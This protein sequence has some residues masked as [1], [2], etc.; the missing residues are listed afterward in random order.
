M[1]KL[2]QPPDQHTQAPPAPP[3]TPDI[4]SDNDS[5][6]HARR[7]ELGRQLGG[8]ANHSRLTEDVAARQPHDD[9]FFSPEIPEEVS[10]FVLQALSLQQKLEHRVSS[11]IEKNDRDKTPTVRRHRKDSDYGRRVA[12]DGHRFV[13]LL[14]NGAVQKDADQVVLTEAGFDLI[15]Y[16]IE[17]NGPPDAKTLVGLQNIVARQ[18]ISPVVPFKKGPDGQIEYYPEVGRANPRYITE[19]GVKI[20]P[21]DNPKQDKVAETVKKLDP[22]H[23][24]LS[25]DDRE[26]FKTLLSTDNLTKPPAPYAAKPHR[27]P[28]AEKLGLRKIAEARRQQKYRK[29]LEPVDQADIELSK[30]IV[31]WFQ[32]KEP[33]DIDLHA[34]ALKPELLLKAAKKRAEPILERDNE[35]RFIKMEQ[36][37]GDEQSETNIQEYLKMYPQQKKQVLEHRMNMTPQEF[38]A[39]LDERFRQSE[40]RQHNQRG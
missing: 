39:Y 2:E 34:D 36:I 31:A 37:I 30:R 23:W 7:A 19:K 16:G 9:P 33:G 14:T 10:P 11:Q 21:Y 29:N 20:G 5:V 38:Q 17:N 8:V 35:L 22:E 18:G 13:E 6:A 12:Q 15:A 26:F 32:Y 24:F 27:Y 28:K 1:H 40:E 3:V 4:I 25:N